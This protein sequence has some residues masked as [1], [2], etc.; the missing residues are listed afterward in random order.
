[1]STAPPDRE[2]LLQTIAPLCKDIAPDILHDFFSRMDPEFFR[3]FDPSTI[4]RHIHLAA[5]LTPDHPSELSVTEMP[6]EHFELT[7]VGYDYFAV[8]ATICG[9]LSAFGLNID[10]GQI[11]TFLDSPSPS[12]ART[13]GAPR[14]RSAVR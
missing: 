3:R 13:S 11:Y 9:L 8:F 1:M 10:E 6:H 12:A 14:G 5:T 2:H 7:I 4:A